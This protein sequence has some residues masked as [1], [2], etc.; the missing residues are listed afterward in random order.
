MEN[1]PLPPPKQSTKSMHRFP[2][3]FQEEMNDQR[4]MN[5]NLAKSVSFLTDLS[6]IFSYLAG[7]GRI[8]FLATNWLSNMTYIYRNQQE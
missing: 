3:F 5:R 1:R 8:W 6:L 4:L 7:H 2:N